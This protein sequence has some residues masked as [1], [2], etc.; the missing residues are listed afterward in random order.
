MRYLRQKSRRFLKYLILKGY[1]AGVS[2]E[3]VKMGVVWWRSCGYFPQFGVDSLQGIQG[4]QR[5]ASI[6]EI[7]FTT[8]EGYR[9]EYR[10]LSMVIQ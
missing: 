1:R 4:I 9:M 10:T 8:Q 5:F 3:T 6:P 7:P 2:N